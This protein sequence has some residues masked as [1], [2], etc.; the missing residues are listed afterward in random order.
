[1]KGSAVNNSTG[2]TGQAGTLEWKLGLK[3]NLAIGVKLQLHAEI[4]SF[5]YIRGK[6]KEIAFTKKY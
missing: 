1:M 2:T 5:P 6:S 4:I 3:S